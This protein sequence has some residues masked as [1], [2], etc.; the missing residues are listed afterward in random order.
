MPWLVVCLL[1]FAAG[2]WPEAIVFPKTPRSMVPLPAL[3]ALA[4][5]QVVFLLLVYP[6]L[7]LRRAATPRIPDPESRIPFHFCPGLAVVE[8]VMLLV[9]AAPFSVAAAWFSD[10]GAADVL[11]AALGVAAMIP[12]SVGLCAWT[13][14]ARPPAAR[15]TALILGLTATAG[16]TAGVYLA[17]EFL[18]PAWADALWQTAPVT[19]AWTCASPQTTPLPIIA[20]TFWLLTGLASLVGAWMTQPKPVANSQ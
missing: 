10:G 16:L 11:R 14:P 13:L 2:L 9:V 4:A 3:S 15:C 1:G 18:R 5:A 8:L 20:L 6:V 12:L 7:V 17:H 19:L